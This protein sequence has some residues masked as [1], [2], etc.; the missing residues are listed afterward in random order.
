M[1]VVPFLKFKVPAMVFSLIVIVLLFGA[2]IARGGFNLGIDFKAGLSMQ[3]TVAGEE[4]SED[5]IS[6]VLK[7]VQGLSVQKAEA[8]FIIRVA[9]NGKE[10]FRETTEALILE[11]INSSFG[12]V[13]LLSS[14]FVA[15]S[16]SISMVFSA[17]YLVLLA[18]ILITLYLWWRFKTFNYSLS[19]ML[20]TFH[21]IFVVVGFIGAF[22]L[23][24][25][26]ATIAAVLTIIGYS[27]NDTIVIFDRIRE[28]FHTEK[29]DKTF[30]NMI[31]IALT[32]TLSRTFITSLT[33][34]ISIMPLLL[35]AKGSVKLFAIEMLV[36][37]VVGT[38]SS[39]FVASTSLNQMHDRTVKLAKQSK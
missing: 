17:T 30:A 36:G 31:D 14:D 21:D 15:P 35:L 20:S 1:N 25:N 3:L 38:Y 23:E 19:A 12:E 13:I 8:S 5:K 37:I 4:I 29:Q 2:T 18:F 6:E 24:V 34:A 26:A 7:D 22:G 9:D 11:K 28:V 10:K 33:T 27:L 39:I 32:Q 16:S